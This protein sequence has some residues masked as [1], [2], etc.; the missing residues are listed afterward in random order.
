MEEQLEDE[1]S[2]LNYYKMAMRLR[3]AFPSIARGKVEN[4]QIDGNSYVCVVTK[5]YQDEK[6]TIV[7][8]LDTFEQKITLSA[9][10]LGFSEIAGELYAMDE[11]TA[12]YEDGE[13]TLPPYSII[14][15]K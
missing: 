1:N 13:L 14:I 8:N 2:I 15:L 9:S 7:I 10:E 3:N 12:S 11:G 6:I 4:H 5:E